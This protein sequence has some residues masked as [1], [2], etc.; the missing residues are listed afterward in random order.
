MLRSTCLLSF[1]ECASGMCSSRVSRP[2]GM[3][4]LRKTEKL[5]R[6]AGTL[7][8]RGRFRGAD[9]FHLE[10]FQD[11]ADFD[12]IEVGDARAALKTGTHF[13]GVILE[14]LQRAEL[15]GVD[16]RAVAHNANLRVALE[17]AVHDVA[18]GHRAR[19]LDAER[20]ADFR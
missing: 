1:S 15:R 18:S 20:I 14:A 4:R 3:E 16:H 13:A 17:N 7:S 6:T 5:L 8:L 2:T 12:V 11:I 19:A 9:L 10:T